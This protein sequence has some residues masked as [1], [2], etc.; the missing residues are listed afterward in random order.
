D[1][2]IV[3]SPLFAAG[4]WRVPATGGVPEEV[5]SPNTEIGER[6]F[7]WPDVWPDG[8]SIL[9]TAGSLDSP[10]DYDE[11]SIEVW[12]P[13]S[14]ERAVL[15]EGA[16]MARLLPPDRLVY[17]RD[18][19]LYVARIDVAGRRVV[20][21]GVP[22]L[23]GVIGASSSGAAYFAVAPNGSL[24]FAPGASNRELSRLVLVEPGDE[25]RPVDLE[26]GPLAHPR[27]SPDGSRLALTIGTGRG[28]VQGDVWTWSLA[29]GLLSRLSFDESGGYPRW[30]PDGLEIA[31]TGPV[32]TTILARRTDGSGT[33]RVLV[34][35]TPNV[36]VALPEAWS[37]DGETVAFTA[38]GGVT[39]DIHLARRGGD[40]RLFEADASSPT[41]SPDGRW[42][43]Y[44]QPPSGDTSRVF[45][46]P[47]DGPGKWQA[48]PE[49][50]SYPHWTARSGEILY[51]GISDPT[52]GIRAV[53]V[54]EEAGGLRLGAPRPRLPDT[55]SFAT[56]T[57]PLVNWDV[58]ADGKRFVF[59][60]PLRDD[61]AGSMVHVILGWGSSLTASSVH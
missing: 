8:R 22:V 36:A 46:R 43:A 28:G 50:G 18:N 48:S 26:P 55:T 4:L 29:E 37:P 54:T 20:E 17:F 33:A 40:P 13:E 24:V 42:L 12:D 2:R 41:F 21:T 44:N 27:F 39:S 34:E 6:T 51:L 45:V 11:A 9:F 7:R 57:A 60:E 47:V 1:D 58:D 23:E 31:Y 5:L 15:V 61:S 56:S 25:P 59:V 38:I 32:G 35:E 49:A 14:G 3:Y 53:A 16:N 19:A 10:N 52:R 30:S